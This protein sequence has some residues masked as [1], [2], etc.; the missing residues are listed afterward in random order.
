M[1]GLSP[2]DVVSVTV[3]LNPIAAA[4]RS[5]NA[6][7]IL[8]STPGVIDTTE[9]LR[10]YTQL[11]GGVDNDYQPGTPEYA[12]AALYFG[13]SPQPSALY[14]GTFA[15]AATSGRLVG[16]VLSAAQQLL[17]NF[18]A[19]TAG[20]L[21]I[22]ID[23]TA[24]TV[25]AIDF[26]GAANLNA[27][28]GILT[29][30]LAGKATVTWNPASQQF[31]VTS[32]SS[33][34]TSSVSF[35]TTPGSGTDVGP[36][37]NFQAAGGGRLAPGSAVETPIQG[38]TACANASGAW[39]Q[40]VVAPVSAIQDSD[41]LAIAAFIEASAVPR[42]YGITTSSAAVLD[43]TNTTDIA[44]AVK[45]AKYN[46]TTVQYS[47]ST[48]HAIASIFGFWNT[49]DFTGQNTT[50]TY[51]FKSEP[52]VTAE[53]LSET[54]AAALRAK[55]CN[56]FAAYSND[57]SIFQEGVMASGIFMD[58]IQ[59][60]DWLQG[61]AQTDVFNAL[62][63]APKI[64]QTDP[65]VNQLVA[66]LDGTFE[67]AVTNGLVA[68]GVW[69]GP[70]LGAIKTG[71]TLSK[72]YYVYAAPVASQSQAQRQSRAAPA[73]QAATTLAGAV[74]SVSVLINVQR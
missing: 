70:A 29:T 23:G 66:V 42:I 13:Q 39:Y 64:P 59:G 65:G 27:V 61:Q 3:S 30:A 10:F 45:A 17:S 11:D 74:H 48:P 43:P 40:A 6:L 16:G 47:S 32:A 51:K 72:G 67:G 38:I 4:I 54:Q 46:R 71:Q 24:D 18:T 63:Q 25:T 44:S 34:S 20:A 53:V 22:T 36:L 52:G 68:P 8:G 26:A 73:L 55:N 28:A 62:Q 57:I 14:I 60:V 69:N 56:V 12:A 33:G 35:S 50:V 31:Y 1:S 58:E 37:F 21:D 9:R 5:L 49:V 2:G 7:L 41:R 15:Q 19:V